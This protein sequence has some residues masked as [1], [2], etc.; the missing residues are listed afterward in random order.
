[1][2]QAKVAFKLVPVMMEM[3]T[4]IVRDAENSGTQTDM[5]LTTCVLVFVTFVHFSELVNLRP[6]DLVIEQ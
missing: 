6:C 4:A 5:R 3:L 2:T 1:M